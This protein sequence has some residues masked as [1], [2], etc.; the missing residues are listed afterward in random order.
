MARDMFEFINIDIY[1][2]RHTFRKFINGK[3]IESINID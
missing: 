3:N 2:Q 1:N